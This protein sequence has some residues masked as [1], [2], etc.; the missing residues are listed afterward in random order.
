MSKQIAEIAC[1]QSHLGASCGLSHP[2]VRVLRADVGGIWEAQPSNE[3]PQL[4][5]VAQST[6]NL[7]EYVVW[8][9]PKHSGQDFDALF[10]RLECLA[11]PSD[12]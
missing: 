8:H 9:M 4:F 6:I 7:R 11:H 3:A 1:T 5:V 2:G 10:V 12:F